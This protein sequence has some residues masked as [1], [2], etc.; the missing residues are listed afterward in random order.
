MFMITVFW[1]YERVIIVDVMTGGATVNITMLRESKECLKR[2]Q[3]YNNP[4]EIFFQN[5]H[6]QPHTCFE[7]IRLDTDNPSK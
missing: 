6:V 3:N 2:N 1:E 4:T 5:D 7:T